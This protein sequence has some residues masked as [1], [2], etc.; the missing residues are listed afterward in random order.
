[1]VTFLIKRDIVSWAVRI[2]LCSYQLRIGTGD[3]HRRTDKVWY[4]KFVSL[5]NWSTL[6]IKLEEK[7]SGV[8]INIEDY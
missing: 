3:T 7:Y 5:H 4:Y 1:M 2:L 6:R 8:V